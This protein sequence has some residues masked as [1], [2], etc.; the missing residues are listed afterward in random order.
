MFINDT[1]LLRKV[2]QDS[3]PS[4]LQ[5]IFPEADKIFDLDRKPIFMNK[6][7][8][9]IFAELERKG[10]PPFIDL[11]V[12]TFQLN[13]DERRILVHIEGRAKDSV[14]VAEDMFRYWYW[15]LDHYDIPVTAITIFT[16]RRHLK[17]KRVPL[18]YKREF[19]G[20]VILNQYNA[21]YIQDQSETRLL[22]MNNLFALVVLAVQK[23]FLRDKLSETELNEQRL[24]IARALIINGH[25]SQQQI[26]DFL[27]F[28]KQYIYINN[29]EI[30]KNFDLETESLTGKINVSGTLDAIVDKAKKNALLQGRREGKIEVIKNLLKLTDFKMAKIANL[31]SVSETLVSK[32]KKT[33]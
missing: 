11:L 12:K 6:E 28:L 18:C 32:I 9:G 4:L 20:T 14:S 5:F 31:A 26:T 16:D 33:L 30:N 15:T 23:A 22:T 21:L 17:N 24:V 3:F 19:F 7:L 8:P 13:G 27:I 29:N 1:A 2:I 25:Y 10:E